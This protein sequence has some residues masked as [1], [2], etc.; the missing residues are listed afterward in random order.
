MLANAGAPEAARARVTDLR[1]R[2]APLPAPPLLADPTGRRARRLQIG[3]R[4]VASVF[5]AWLCGLLLAG[6]GLLPA[7]DLPLGTALR[8]AQEPAQ[9]GPAAA[10]QRA[11]GLKTRSGRRVA[12][13]RKVQSGRSRAYRAAMGSSP[14]ASNAQPS[15]QGHPAATGSQAPTATAPPTPPSSSPSASPP[16]AT[17][18][19]TSHG[20]SGSAPGQQRHQSTTTSSGTTT[21]RGSS[22]TA[23][24]HDPT[25]TTGHG[26]PKA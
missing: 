5:L 21:A 20:H 19:T 12:S 11:A 16:R 26:K 13:S 9:L 18:T 15:G 8:T 24:G 4:V 10:G 2:Y 6:L 14:V 7:S 23:P 25:R 22:S 3:G 17:T 1:G